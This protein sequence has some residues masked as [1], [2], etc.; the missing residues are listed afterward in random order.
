MGFEGHNTAYTIGTSWAIPKNVNI[1][2]NNGIATPYDI[3]I[4]INQPGNYTFRC[5]EGVDGDQS[6]TYYNYL[7]TYLYHNSQYTLDG[8]G[9][10]LN[11]TVY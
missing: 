7:G 6:F 11:L 1:I 8:W 10:D 4:S 9:V 3:N 5:A 2:S